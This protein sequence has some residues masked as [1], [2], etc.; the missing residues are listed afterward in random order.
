MIKMRD[1]VE[2]SPS[3]RANAPE[4]GLGH[5]QDSRAEINRLAK[6]MSEVL[7]EIAERQEDVKAIRAAAKANGYNVKV[8]NQCVKELRRG[9]AFQAAQ[10]ELELEVDT[11]RIAMGLPTNL[12][13]ARSIVRDEALGEAAE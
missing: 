2:S 7:D 11:Y 3:G 8:L 13:E 6:R 5:N 4:G 10:L 1:S 12:D 9:A